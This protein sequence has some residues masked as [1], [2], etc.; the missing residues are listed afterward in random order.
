[1]RGHRIEGADKVTGRAPFVDDLRADAL[2]FTPLIA[3]AVTA[4]VG[5]GVIQRIEAEAALAV[6]GVRAVVSHLNAPRLRKVVSLSMSE[7]GVRL[8][9]QSPKIDYAGQVVALVVAETLAAARQGVAAVTVEIDKDAPPVVRLSDAAGRLKAVKRAGIGPGRSRKGDVDAALASAAVTIDEAVHN[10]AHHQNPIEPGAVIARWDED[11]GLTVHAAVQWHHIDS[12]MIGQAF[13]LGWAEGLPGLLNRVLR[14]ARPDGKVRLVNHFSGGAFGRNISYQALLLAPLAAKVAGAPV[15]FVHTRRDTFSLMSHRAEVRQRLRLGAHKDG[16]LAAIVLEPD[17]AKGAAAFVEPVG[18]MPMQLYAH[19]THR[20]STHV[21]GLDLPGAG[22]MRG[23]GVAYAIFAL[24]QGMDRLAAKLGMDPLEIRLRNHADIHPV[25]GK[26]WESKAL[27]DAYETGAAAIGWHD[28]PAGGTPRPDGRLT[29]YGMASAIDLGRQFPATAHVTL[30]RDGTAI[31]SLAVAEMGQGL[32]TGLTGLIAEMAGVTPDKVDLRRQATSEGYAA[33]SIGSTGT[34]S[35]AA[36][37]LDAIGRIARGLADRARKD[38]TSPLFGRAAKGARIAGEFLVL[39]DGTRV[40]L[41]DLLARYGDQTAS[42]RAGLTFGASS[43]AKASF[44]AV[45]CE[46]AVDPVTLDLEVVRLIGAYDC[47]RVLQPA[48][49]SAQLRGA[50]IMGLGQALM[51]ET[52]LDRRSG[53]WTNA[54]LGEAFIPTQADVRH[55]EA[56]TV[57]GATTD[58]PLDFKGIA[59]TA[60]VGVAPAIASAFADATGGLIRSLP[61]THTE[62]LRAVRT[63]KAQALKEAA[64]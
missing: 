54:E 10:A 31:V 48:I 9:L 2:G 33:G 1:M 5:R 58:G 44:G 38:R 57:R 25:S 51:E 17:I 37:I 18:E 15:K 12:M 46:M 27:R 62:R 55:V 8:P 16:R 47:G 45:F 30:T 49:A 41:R 64:E 19:D 29:G 61:M 6:P 22:W 7:P 26:P 3:M 28:R 13:G 59:E 24:E 40:Q 32:L 23:P 34:Y 11:G 43:R 53:A 52:R 50:M 4:P 20:L 35:N 36:A 21:A 14:K 42:G 63:A 39:T 56:I 60:I